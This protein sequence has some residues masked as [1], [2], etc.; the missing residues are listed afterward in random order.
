MA[1]EQTRNKRNGRR[2]RRLMKQLPERRSGLVGNGYRLLLLLSAA[3]LIDVAFPAQS[4]PDLAL[5]REDQVAD[6]EVI[7]PRD[8]EVR[9]SDDDLRL[10]RMAAAN[11]VAPILDHRPE[12]ADQSI[13]EA[14]A[15]FEAVATRLEGVQED[16]RRYEAVREVLE[17]YRIPVSENRVTLLERPELRQQL[18][19]AITR[20]YRSFLRPGA[21]Q[22]S[23]LEQA[24]STVV[25]LRETD[26]DRRMQRDSLQTIQQ[27]FSRAAARAPAQF[28]M[29]EHRLYQYL[30]I[31]F[32]NPTIVFNHEATQ[33]LRNEAREAVDPVKYKVL[34]GERIV[35]AHE[36]IGPTEIE[37]LNALRDAMAGTGTKRSVRAKLGGMLYNLMLLIAFAGVLR[38]FRP[39]IY[40]SNR[41]AALIWIIVLAVAGAGALIAWFQAPAYLLPVAFAA[42]VLASLY[43]GLIALITVVVLVGLVAIRPPLVGVAVLFPILMGGTAAALGGRVVRRRAHMWTFATAIAGAYV[44]AAASLGLLGRVNIDDILYISFWGTVDA[45]GCALFA[46]GVLPLAETFTKITTDQTLLELADLNRPLLR[47]LSLEAPGTYAHSINVANLAE[48]AARAIDAN[49]LLVRVGVYYHDVG[50]VEKPQYFVENQPRGRNPHDKLKPT[51][52]ANIV[53][54]HV[55]IGRKLAED[56]GIPDSVAAFINE[57][58]G[59]ARISF[60]WDRA[61]ELDPE[62]EH[63]PRD[64]RYPGPKPQSKETAIALL[65]DSVESAARTL[66]DPTHA[67]ITEL[68][69]R[70]VKGKIDDSQLDDTPLTLRE[71]TRIKEQFVKVLTG[72]YHSRIDYPTQTETESEPEPSREASP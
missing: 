39:R 42:L 16:G 9:K 41:S 15:F 28:G 44:L 11:S 33:A 27:F 13:D 38:Y 21:V 35:A 57:H 20:A 6:E 14:T 19:A 48:A 26:G 47:R 29:S 10:E 12:A 69:D 18:L 4:E 60:F 72:M 54:E 2:L 40:A 52:S 31:R 59:D 5:W 8:F 71:L 34:K 61:K 37:K 17:Q 22:T 53:R 36:R 65:A 1:S 56:S 49:S 62:G 70:I 64:F 58:H 25:V 63:N 51:T 23:D 30:L 32:T 7:A 55:E 50:K 68:V 45:I 46:W 66:Q 67:S 24:A 43:D 3:V